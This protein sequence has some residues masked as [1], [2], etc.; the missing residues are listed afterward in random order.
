MLSY[1]TQ[2]ESPQLFHNKQLPEDFIALANKYFSRLLELG[3]SRRKRP[4]FD[5]NI[6]KMLSEI[7]TA[8]DEIMSSDAE[9]KKRF[10][11]AKSPG[12]RFPFEAA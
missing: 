1:C 12:R 3:H 6:D 7:R 2:T 8:L 11:P 4:D 10:F 5:N 9:L